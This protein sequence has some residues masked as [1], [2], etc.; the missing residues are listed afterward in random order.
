MKTR[1]PKDKF[2]NVKP[3]Y[4]YRHMRESTWDR[5][6]D[7]KT[8]NEGKTALYIHKGVTREMDMGG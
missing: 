5:Y 2:Q 7:A 1:N 3:N 8:R 6:A 4:V